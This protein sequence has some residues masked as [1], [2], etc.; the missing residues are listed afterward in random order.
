M[1]INTEITFGFFF[2]WQQPHSQKQ[3]GRH[4]F[5][6]HCTIQCLFVCLF[7]A[8]LSRQ[9]KREINFPVCLQTLALICTL[10]TTL[11]VIPCCCSSSSSLVH[12]LF[13]ALSREQ[14]MCF[15]QFSSVLSM[16][17]SLN[18]PGPFNYWLQQNFPQNTVLFMSRL[19]IPNI[20]VLLLCFVCT[21][22]LTLPPFPFPP[23][24]LFYLSIIN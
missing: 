13:L 4:S 15:V 16:L 22:I 21:H 24:F 19:Y 23:P 11:T 9:G 3:S 10:F 7:A 18:H 8:C 12:F 1:S 2:G 20:A 14:P 5:I 6:S 17:A